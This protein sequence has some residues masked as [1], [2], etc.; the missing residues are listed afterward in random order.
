VFL[1]EYL[2]IE[3]FVQSYKQS[4]KNNH[5]F[6]WTG[7]SNYMINTSSGSEEYYPASF[8]SGLD[9]NF[10]NHLSI[11]SASIRLELVARKRY[12]LVQCVR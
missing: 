9:I 6:S 4:R 5:H 11:R 7:L 8:F 2:I 10:L 1:R 12:L 3:G